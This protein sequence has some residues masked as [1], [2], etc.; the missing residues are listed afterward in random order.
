MVL[1]QVASSCYVSFGAPYIR[2]ILCE[3]GTKKVAI[4]TS[5]SESNRYFGV[6]TA[7]APHG[8]PEDAKTG[9]AIPTTS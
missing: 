3:A 4:R 5:V 1:L 6:A 9:A 7:T 2:E 8:S